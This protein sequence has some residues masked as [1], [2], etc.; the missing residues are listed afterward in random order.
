[1]DTEEL[2]AAAETLETDELAE[3]AP[4]LPQ[5]VMDD[6]FRSLPIEERE[7]LRA[8]MSFE[9]DM[10]G[11]LMDFEMFTVRPAVPLGFG[12]GYLRRLAD[13]RDQTARLLLADRVENLLGILP[14]NNL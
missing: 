6:V 2:V 1:M 12:L 3:L 14:F 13:L 8:A 7:R 10:I 4:D 11:A 5:E 9:D